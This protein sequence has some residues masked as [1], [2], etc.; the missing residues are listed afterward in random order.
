[1]KILVV[2]WG[3]WQGGAYIGGDNGGVLREGR[4]L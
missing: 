2:F 3:R 1:M 4:G